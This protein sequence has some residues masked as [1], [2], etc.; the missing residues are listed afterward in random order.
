M[1]YSDLFT[2][3]PI[4]TVIQLEHA[5]QKSEAERLVNRF[6][7]TPSLGEA[8]EN[9]AVPQL[10]WTSGAEGKGIFVV[11][12][13]GTGKSH[14]MSFLSILAE[15]ATLVDQ[16][17]DTAWQTKLKPFAGKYK[18]RR[19][20]IAGSLMNLYQILAEELEKL[21]KVSGFAFTFKPQNQVSNVKHEFAR[22]MEAF[23]TVHPD[24]GVLLVIDEL[25]HFL[26]TRPDQDLVLDLSVLQGLGEFSNGSRFVFMAG[27]QQT[28][29]NNPRFNHVAEEVNRVKQRFNDFV[30]DSKG[31][32]ELIEQ[33]LFE[34]TIAQKDAIRIILQKQ[35]PLFEV[36][37]S[38]IENFVR[39]FP[40]HPRFVAEFEKVFVVERR[41]ILKVLSQEAK[42]LADQSLDENALAL[43]TT[44]RYWK[45]VEKD[46]G[47]NA[48][49]DVQKIKKN[50][51]TLKARI[52]SDLPSN[53]DKAGAER[54]VEA[55]A[56]NR[57][58]TQSINDP[59]G[60]KPEEL[61]NNLLWRIKTPMQS[62]TFLTQ[63][64]KILLD[65]T[66]TAANGQYL[67]VAETSGQYFIDPS[68]D[69]DYDQEV[70][71]AAEAL[72]G[73]VTQRYLNEVLTRALLIDNEAPV[74]E[75]RLWNYQLPWDAHKVERPGWLFF[76]FPNQ[77]ST[78]KPPKDFYLFLQPSKRVTKQAESFTEKPDEVYFYFE[79]FPACHWDVAGALGGSDPPTFLDHL[80]RYAGARE[81]E[82]AC[83]GD[84]KVAYHAIAEKL[85]K[86][87]MPEFA[88]HAKDWV[89]ILFN[90]KQ[91]SL[92]QWVLD[93]D[94]TQQTAA[95]KTQVDTV[96]KRLLEPH[97]GARYPSYPTFPFFVTEA[98]RGQSTRG[99]LEVVFGQGMQ[100]Q[101]GYG[102]LEALGL[103]SGQT[104]TPDASPWLD[105]IRKELTAI[106]ATQVL[107]HSD[108]FE[109]RDDKMW[110][111]GQNI[112]GE[113]LQVVLAAGVQA[114]DLVVIGP[115]GKRY[116]ADNPR[117][118]FTEL[119]NLD[120]IKSIR[121]PSEL[122]IKEW[123]QLFTLLGLKQ[124]NL[125]NPTTYDAAVT[126]FQKALADR[127]TDLVA[128]EQELKSPL[129]L[130]DATAQGEVA[131][132]LGAF[133]EV[134]TVL[135]SS[136]VPINTKAKMQNLKLTAQEITTL[137]D[138]I[139][140]CTAL[141][142]LLAFVK[143]HAQALAA[144]E[145]LGVLLGDRDA[146]FVT[147]H[148]A[149]V[150]A[151]NAVYAAPETLVTEKP[152][153]DASIS[154]ARDAGLKAYQL[155]HKR[156][157]LD[158][159]GD[160]AKVTLTNSKTL[161]Q[162]NKLAAVKALSTNKLE[163]LRRRLD[164]LMF[165]PGC[166]DSD[167]LKSSL[168]LC[169][170]CKFDPSTLPA[171]A[172]AASDAM[173]ACEQE[174]AVLHAAWT[175]Q[176]LDELKDPLVMSGLKVLKPE[177][178]TAVNALL[179]SSTIP[180]PVTDIFVAALNTVLSG[181]TRKGITG[182]AL[183]TALF[184]DGTP[185]KPEELR[186]RFEEWLKTQVGTDDPATVRFVMEP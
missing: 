26:Q 39:L 102:V 3:N 99:A 134:K 2:L 81:R 111:K 179:A 114:G 80:R 16:I 120:D 20:Q 181:L 123:R 164:L 64:A 90:G 94:P 68:R 145:R 101:N 113:W 27:I 48:N 160:T 9:V 84:E 154:A 13:Y 166:S 73:Q 152:T 38:D 130:A 162:L 97:F 7:I 139:T 126:D 46:T 135:E 72:S 44:D 75:G 34:K 118:F 69:R 93:L 146:D 158:K 151:L 169:P 79:D 131:K 40:A 108:L 53:A 57:L 35:A 184:G 140:V 138:K 28:L 91:Q 159:N 107:N 105:V 19:C 178:F 42:A 124:G 89:T 92:R 109:S 175:K 112:E 74:M 147:K 132:R 174:V 150:T 85:I 45:H 60:L 142:E 23:E 106:G 185:L 24:L 173:T 148:N 172:P 18:V 11:G 58:T 59:I 65:Q 129:A 155:L 136:L 4:E 153:L 15:K 52:Q 95:F 66:R 143:G 83:R 86:Q 137:G 30:I 171:T 63:S 56:V 180:D 50:V 128:Q 43:I 78:A 133:G 176:L 121:R 67:A 100:T 82:Q 36:V 21:A 182:T 156:Y 77:R 117:E 186:L 76:G 177:E 17:R 37:G 70:T 87:L 125:A 54:L 29:F 157:R 62:A 12:N 116:G 167:L 5:D 141:S 55:L 168:T 1:N 49:R 41:E 161:Q 51:E 8:L 149:L 122:P 22:F 25:L 98:S 110:W 10:D 115:N 119:K 96:A 88:E 32:S 6:V 165:C 163:D 127:I 71:T 170:S 103:Y 61:K 144:I 14:V 33:Y 47:L 183:S 104:F 31:V